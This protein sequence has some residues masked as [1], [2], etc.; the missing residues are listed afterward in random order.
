MDMPTISSFFKKSVYLS[1]FIATHSYAQHD[2]FVG[3]GTQDYQLLEHDLYSQQ[4]LVAENGSLL[5]VTYGLNYQLSPKFLLDTQIQQS[6]GVIDYDGQTQTGTPHQ[7]DSAHTISQGSVHVGFIAHQNL[8]LYLGLQGQ[9]DVR[10][11]KNKNGVYGATETYNELFAKAG[12]KLTQS[13]KQHSFG[14]WL[15]TSQ[16]I[17][18]ESFVDGR[19]HDDITLRLSKG[20]GSAWG[21]DYKYLYNNNKGFFIKLQSLEYDYQKS[22]VADK[23]IYG[24]QTGYQLYQPPISFKLQSAYMG[25]IWLFDES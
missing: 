3:V 23:T 25:L 2:I 19:V 15:E 8:Q 10:D 4:Q 21:I 6:Y 5:S 18:T 17:Y 14:L 24:Q 20:S 11:V 13:L 16:P 7:T 1:I 9:Q 12:L 22:T